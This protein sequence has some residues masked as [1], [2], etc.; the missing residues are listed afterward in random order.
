VTTDPAP[1]TERLATEPGWQRLDPRMLL[2]HPIKEVGR[3]LPVLVGIVVAG[4]QASG[5][6]WE[7]LGLAIPVV[8]GMLRYYTTGYRVAGGRIEL[9]RGLVNKHVL[10]TQ[11]DRVRTVD[12]T[13]SPIHRVLGLTTVRIGTGT[14]S[15]KDDDQIALDGLPTAR[16][17]EM[18]YQLL[19]AAGTS[20]DRAQASAPL[21]ARTVVRFDLRWIR[22]APLT[23]SGLVIFLAT[24][25]AV[26]QGLNNIGFFNHAHRVPGFT[27]ALWVVIP[28]LVAGGLITMSVLAIAGYLLTNWDFSL[29]HTSTDGSWHLRRGLLTTRETSMDDGRVRGVAVGEPLGLRLARGGR[30]S[31]IVTG[32]DRKQ[33]GSTLLVPPAPRTVVDRVAAEVVGT[34]TPLTTPLHSHGPRATRRRW[35]RAEAL[36]LLALLTMAVLVTSADAPA[37]TLGIALA[38]L[39]LAAGL[40]ADRVRSLGHAVVD[41]FFVVR[42]G[43]LVRRREILETTG[44]IGWNLRA[45]LFQR[46]AGLATLV[47]TTAGGR[48]AYA[49][50]D[51]PEET[52][53][54]VAATAHPEMLR[55][56][57]VT[58]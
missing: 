41:G 1:S 22:F 15:K 33:Q 51:V 40:A 4:T 10:A 44:V 28:L 53:V 2:V 11:L 48:Q 47:A 6:P 18:R 55:Q 57:L 16:A 17:H 21:V 24:F 52:A 7:L 45:T 5:A 8:I 39:L 12:L 43:S 56:F 34:T 25:G 36:P 23:S 9:R 38:A 35:T 3:F 13:A 42:S 30:L 19:H 26:S 14:A 29:T 32:L 20:T 54:A 31:A 58:G 37:W 49:A 50:L 46:R 27:L